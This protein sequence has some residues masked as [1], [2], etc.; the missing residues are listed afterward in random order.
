MERRAIYTHAGGSPGNDVLGGGRGIESVWPNMGCSASLFWPQ[1][2][3]VLISN[4]S[5]RLSCRAVASQA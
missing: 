2:L 5:L 1:T 4:V 3:T